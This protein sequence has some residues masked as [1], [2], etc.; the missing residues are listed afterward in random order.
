MKT[1]L[2]SL[3]NGNSTTCITGEVA[4][5]KF[6][7]AYG[8]ANASME[9]FDAGLDSSETDTALEYLSRLARACETLGTIPTLP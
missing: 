6:L 5:D 2:V 7:D 3:D 9:I 8:W 4:A 1:I